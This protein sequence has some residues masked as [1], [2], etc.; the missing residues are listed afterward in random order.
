MLQEKW[1]R[2]DINTDFSFA[3]MLQRWSK[4][5]QNASN[6][7]PTPFFSRRTDPSGGVQKASFHSEHSETGEISPSQQAWLDKTA[8]HGALPPCVCNRCWWNVLED[9]LMLPW[10]PTLDNSPLCRI[11]SSLTDGP[12]TSVISTPQVLFAVRSWSLR[13]RDTLMISFAELQEL[14]T[15]CSTLL[16]ATQTFSRR[17]QE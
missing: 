9:L 8:F 10:H 13:W 1:K 6:K 17:L 5:F 12:R 2:C 14:Q 11:D 3:L 4:E 7:D 16:R 15:I